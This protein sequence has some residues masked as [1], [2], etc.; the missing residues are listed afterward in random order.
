MVGLAPPAALA[1][2]T[3]AGAER[4]VAAGRL[5]ACSWAL[6][7]AR[8]MVLTAFDAWVE[9]SM[10][11]DALTINPVAA[12]RRAAAFA[13]RVTCVCVCACV[14]V[15]GHVRAHAHVRVR[16]RVCMFVRVC[17]RLY[18]DC[19]IKIVPLCEA[20]GIINNVQPRCCKY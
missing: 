5:A 17:A 6:M 2:V 15:R 4:R 3:T 10:A 7:A 1:P 12:P 19:I 13:V 9:L 18:E 11:M 8:V 16:V 20:I 14:R